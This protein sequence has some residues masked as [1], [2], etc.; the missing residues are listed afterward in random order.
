MEAE[1]LASSDDRERSDACPDLQ[2]TMKA[3]LTTILGAA[4]LL[5]PRVSSAGDGKNAELPCPDE[6]KAK[7]DFVKGRL[8]YRRGNYEKAIIKWQDSYAACQRPLTLF[9]IGNA[10]ERLGDY[11]GALENLQKYRPHAEKHERADLDSRIAK[12]EAR[13]AKQKEEERKAKEEALRKQNQAP[14]PQPPRDEGTGVLTWAGWITGGV[15]VAA[16]VGGT[17]TGILALSLDG[18]L[19]DRCAAG[20]CPTG[21][22]SDIDRLGALS[23]ATDVLLIAG[24]ALTAGGVLMLVLDPHGP[25]TTSVGLSVAPGLYGATLQQRF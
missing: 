15:G 25:F 1:N 24:A 2:R 13:V 4:L 22:A 12:L 3:L 16:L 6:A 9:N 23:T 20:T 14:Q 17:V 18:D 5:Q 7:D 19:A 11:E 21:S 8:A 10:Y